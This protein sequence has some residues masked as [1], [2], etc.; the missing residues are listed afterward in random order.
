[1]DQCADAEAVPSRVFESSWSDNDGAAF[2]PKNIPLKR[3]VRAWERQP[4]SPHASKNGSRKVWR[5]VRMPVFNA[6]RPSEVDFAPSL[7]KAVSR[8]ATIESPKKAVKKLCVKTRYGQDWK[9]TEWDPRGVHMR[10]QVLRPPIVL[11]S[12]AR[13]DPNTENNPVEEEDPSDTPDALSESEAIE[14]PDEEWEDVESETDLDQDRSEGD[15][16]RPLDASSRESRDTSADLDPLED[17]PAVQRN[18]DNEICLQTLPETAETTASSGL[19]YSHQ[20]SPKES[21]EPPVDSP[22]SEADTTSPVKKSPKKRS[23]AKKSPS[24]R[25]IDIPALVVPSPV[26]RP[27]SAPPEDTASSESRYRPRISDDTAILHAFLSRA[28]ASKKPIAK[29][30]SLTNRRDSGMVRHALASPA[31]PE[32]LAELDANSSSP[33]KG[34]RTEVSGVTVAAEK[35][36]PPQ[37]DGDSIE[38]DRPKRRSARSRGKPTLLLD[39]MT[40]EGATRAPSKITIR[41]PTEQV[42]LRKNEVQELAAQT[43]SNTRKNK[44]QSVMPLARL[45]ELANAPAAGASCGN[46]SETHKGTKNVRWDETLTYFSKSPDDAEAV[47]PEALQAPDTANALTIEEPPTSPTKARSKRKHAGASKATTEAVPASEEAPAAATPASKPAPSKRR[48]RIATPAKG[49]LGKS[50]LLP[51]DASATESEPSRPAAQTPAQAKKPR[52]LPTPKRSAANVASALKQCKAEV[53]VP[54]SSQTGTVPSGR[55]KEKD[56]DRDKERQRPHSL[57]AKPPLSPRKMGTGQG[58]AIPSLTPFAPRMSGEI[59]RLN[60]DGVGEGRKGRRKAEE[61]EDGMVPGL[62]SPAKRRRGVLG[63]RGRGG[64]EGRE[65][66]R[67]VDGVKGEVLG[68]MSPAKK[69]TRSAL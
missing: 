19:D 5:R 21:A 38:D 11:R 25:V 20:T 47:A 32:I 34:A 13:I 53:P 55:D 40:S 2:L 30:E 69:R 57:L 33:H 4:H 45:T 12:G 46:T 7:S 18:G 22:L 27:T 31:K 43:R 65:P 50:S 42:S 35:S 54:P 1:M 37:K 9:T 49:L 6:T 63:V 56:K 24:K 48:S 26:E 68:L 8:P 67:Y 17:C 44:G 3:A 51:E 58:S 16:A 28:A 60:F 29:R 39:Q 61:A 62:A 36:G 14:T 41:G 66:E 10:K 15:E 59:P 64:E 52:S 23:P